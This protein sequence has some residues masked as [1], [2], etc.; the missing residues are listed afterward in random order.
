MAR[1][2]YDTSLKDFLKDFVGDEALSYKFEEGLKKFV[3]TRSEG[4]KMEDILHLLT[5]EELLKICI[6]TFEIEIFLKRLDEKRRE[7]SAGKIFNDPIHGSM[8][9]HPAC[10]LI[11]DTPQFQ[12]LRYIKQLGMCYFVFPGA[13]H[14]RFEHSIG[15]CYLAGQFCRSLRENQ[16]ELGITDMDI[17]CVEIAGLCHDL[18][19]GPFSRLFVDRFLP[20]HVEGN[21]HSR[22]EYARKHKVP[23]AL[24]FDFLLRENVAVKRDLATKYDIWEKELK[25][26]KEQIDGPPVTGSTAWPYKGRKEHKAYLYEIVSNLRNG[27]DVCKW[28]YMARDCH[29]LGLRNNFDHSRYMKFARVIEESGEH[30]ICLRDKEAGNVYNMFYTRYTLNKYA[31]KHPA[32]CA[33]EE[34]VV[35][36]LKKVEDNLSFGREDFF[37][38]LKKAEEHLQISKEWVVDVV[39]KAEEH[40]KV[41]KKYALEILENAPI[42]STDAS[43]Q[44]NNIL[45]KAQ[46]DFNGASEKVNNILKEAQEDFK[47]AIEKVNILTKAQEDFNGA[48]E[49]VNILT[50]AQED[51]NGASEKVNNILKEAQEDFK[52]AIEK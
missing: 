49:K 52:G 2:F 27:I 41:S 23:S 5:K 14:N 4:D 17:L 24:M 20:K 32:N 19:H 12:R 28:D 42:D 8:E 37:D 31:Y 34:M 13:S 50:K 43:S 16:P 3:A 40:L 18:G 51:F 1:E 21:G 45:T 7:F 35:D 11:I 25:F 47:G 26:I 9:I 29:H 30:Q 10:V 22:R 39:K 38:V 48:S 15:T 6:D 46:E 36:I 33:I 44:V